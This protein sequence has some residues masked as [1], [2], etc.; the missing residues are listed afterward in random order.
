[1]FLFIVH[2]KSRNILDANA[3]TLNAG[4]ADKTSKQ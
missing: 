1:M 3:N 2:L 4:V